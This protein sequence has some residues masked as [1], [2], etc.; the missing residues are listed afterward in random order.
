M[1]EFLL[2]LSVYGAM[3]GGVAALLGFVWLAAYCVN[4][5]R[6]VETRVNDM[7]TQLSERLEQIEANTR[8]DARIQRRIFME[9]MMNLTET[10]TR[11][12]QHISE[13]NEHA[14]EVD[15]GGDEVLS[16]G[17]QAE[18]FNEQMLTDD[19]NLSGIMAQA[20]TDEEQAENT[21]S[22]TE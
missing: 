2:F 17:E 3:I 10:M 21:E 11:V 15:E 16:G 22:A 12:I 6:R 14:D 18:T 9:S 13:M 19:E 20:Q 7:R 1:D 4:T 5:M 8:E